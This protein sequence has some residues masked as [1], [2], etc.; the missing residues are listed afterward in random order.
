[1][2]SPD[3]DREL[4]ELVDLESAN[5]ARLREQATG[6]A[7]DVDHMIPLQCRTACGLHTWSNLQ[8]IPAA[9]NLRKFNRMELTTPGE[10]IGKC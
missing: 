7:W 10:W 3:W 6:F 8:V 9:M 1:M 5:L 2:A 4:T